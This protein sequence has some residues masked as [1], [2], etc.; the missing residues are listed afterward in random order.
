MSGAKKQ[1]TNATSSASKK[2]FGIPKLLEQIKTQTKTKKQTYAK[3][4]EK[5]TKKR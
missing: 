5:D 2:R 4:A 1:T 3:V